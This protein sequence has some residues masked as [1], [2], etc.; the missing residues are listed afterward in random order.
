MF[1]APKGSPART[2]VTIVAALIFAAIGTAYLLWRFELGS[3]VERVIAPG[4][5]SYE[6]SDAPSD[7][8]REGRV[9][10]WLELHEKPLTAAERR[11]RIDRRAI[12]GLIAYEA[13]VNVH[14][15][16]YG[17]IV[18]WAGPGKVRYKASPFGEGLPASKEVE[19]LGLLPRR[20]VEQRKALLARADWSML[21]IGA[22]MRALA[23][24]ERRRT[25]LDVS[26]RPGALVTLA[27]A[28]TVRQAER[29][30]ATVPPHR[31]SMAYNFPGNWA[32]NREEQLTAI[33]GSPAAGICVRK[34]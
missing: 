29:Y 9:G 15:S 26:C 4:A 6:L 33:V 24:V 13:M 21:Y 22:I 20:S 25:G 19:Q 1:D 16:R 30:Y 34:H 17:G 8:T 14:L 5:I 3:R 23:D 11:F 7:V 10:R 2:S 32:A 28:W 18:R 12:A 27:S 31:Y